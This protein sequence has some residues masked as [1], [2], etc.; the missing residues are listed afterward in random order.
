MDQKRVWLCYFEIV[1]SRFSSQ[2]SVTTLVKTKT[3]ES[4]TI[5]SM[6]YVRRAK[7]QLFFFFLIVEQFFF[8]FENL[9]KKEYYLDVESETRFGVGQTFVN[10]ITTI[11]GRPDSP[12]QYQRG[13]FITTSQNYTYILKKK[14]YKDS[15]YRIMKKKFIGSFNVLFI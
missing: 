3:Y 13:F 2:S 6:G 1:S 12:I 5:L 14:L 4:C 9:I 7:D 10:W 8:F 15:C 11:L